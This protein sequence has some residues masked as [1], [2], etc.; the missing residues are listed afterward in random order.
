MELSGT[1]EIIWLNHF[2]AQKTDEE[3]ETQRDKIEI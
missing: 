1:F 3:G 2:I